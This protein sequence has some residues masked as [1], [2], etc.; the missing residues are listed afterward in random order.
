MRFIPKNSK[1]KFTFTHGITIPDVIVG[2]VGTLLLVLAISS[3]LEWKWWLALV[4]AILFIPLFIS[5]DDVR[6]Y[7]FLGR[8]VKYLFS[9]KEYK[10]EDVAAIIPYRKIKDGIIESGDGGRTAVIEIQ[11]VGMSMLSEDAQNQIIDGC[12]KN[13]LNLAMNGQCWILTKVEQPLMMDDRIQ[14]EIDRGDSLVKDSEDGRMTEEETAARLE[15]VED[16]IESEG[17]LNTHGGKYARF[18]LSLVGIDAGQVT[19][20]AQRASVILSSSGISNHV[21]TNEEL[22]TFVRYS[23]NEDFDERDSVPEEEYGKHILPKEVRFHASNITQDGKTI[24]SFVVSKY[25]SEVGNCWAARLFAIPETKVVMRMTPVEKGKALKRLD[26]SILEIQEKQGKGKASS[27]MEQDSHIDSLTELLAELQSDSQKLFDTEIIISVYDE[28]GKSTNAKNVKQTLREMS[29]GFSPMF[30]NQAESYTASFSSKTN[31]VKI[32]RGI[33]SSSLAAACP[34]EGDVISDKDGLL[35]GETSMPAF[36]NFFRRDSSHVNSNMIIIGQSGSGKSYATKTVLAGLATTGA[37]IYVLDPEN[38]Y[39][40]LARNLEGVDLDVSSGRWGK[41]NPFQV[42]SVLEDGD[43]TNGLG[44]HLQFVEQFFKVALPGI[45]QDALELLDRITMSAYERKGIDSFTDLKGL[46]PEDFPTFQD[47][48]GIIR[49]RIA[50]EKDPYT[51]GNL[52]VVDN[53]LAKFGKGEMYANLWNGPTTFSAD[54][55]FVA[56]DFQR[57]LA[58]RNE[59]TANAQMLLILKWLDEEI[60]KNR[61]ANLKS[62]RHDKVVVAIDEAHLF[63]DEKFP[64]ALDFMYQLAKRIR[65]YDGMLIMV[66]QNVKDFMGTPEIAKKSQGIINVSQYSMIF[67]LAPNDMNDLAELYRSA[68]GLNESERQDIVHAPRGNAFFITSASH[69]TRLSIWASPE[70]VDTFS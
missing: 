15:L 66:T 56:F 18:Y 1:V 29:I 55:N 45:S 52:R 23:N 38:E 26:N 68:G 49:E 13:V 25:P 40:D 35:L 7:S 47:L 17:E 30:G 10:G 3:N 50:N 39:G 62:G 65:K 69:R 32:A 60:I 59:T 42:T 37:K 27:Q 53:Y 31:E 28:P 48:I 5:I 63:I 57:L 19:E 24:T 8:M 22:L 64:V 61:D 16:R 34:F 14:E 44:I 70:T 6:L 33:Q 46:K 12:L 4:I 20:Q 11:T 36:V 58:N 2:A 51:L 41:I 67:Q 43:G 54:S 21:L 9:K